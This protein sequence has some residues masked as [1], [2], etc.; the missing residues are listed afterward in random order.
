MII[1]YISQLTYDSDG[2]FPEAIY[3][4]EVDRHEE[5]LEVSSFVELKSSFNSNLEESCIRLIGM[6][7]R[8]SSRSAF[9][10]L[11]GNDIHGH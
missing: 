4:E 1:F 2:C 11:A 5:Y 3:L 10:R 9:G 6:S 8:R 7:G